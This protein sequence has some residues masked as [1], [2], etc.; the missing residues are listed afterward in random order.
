MSDSLQ[1]PSNPNLENQ[2]RQL[3]AGTR[4]PVARDAMLMRSKQQIKPSQ[5]G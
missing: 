4:K 1:F 5:M 3:M 2:A